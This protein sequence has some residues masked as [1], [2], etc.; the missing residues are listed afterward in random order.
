[1]QMVVVSL[2]ASRTLSLALIGIV[3]IVVAGPADLLNK[4][5]CIVPMVGWDLDPRGP[6]GPYVLH[7]ITKHWHL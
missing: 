1:M 4:R 5:V 3:G 7:F 2:F 6:D